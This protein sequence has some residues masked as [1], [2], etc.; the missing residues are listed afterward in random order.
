MASLVI[1]FMISAGVNCCVMSLSRGRLVISKSGD[2]DQEGIWKFSGVHLTNSSSVSVIYGALR[3]WGQGWLLHVCISLSSADRCISFWVETRC[4]WTSL[5]QSVIF[6]LTLCYFPY[7]DAMS[8]A[9]IS[10]HDR[11]K[12]HSV[13]SYITFY[14]LSY[15]KT[16][17]PQCI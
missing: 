15:L 1:A 14:F 11:R 13:A 4:A 17:S 7:N 12:R 9:S 10:R 2:E 8:W 16:L 6:D 3:R 5:E